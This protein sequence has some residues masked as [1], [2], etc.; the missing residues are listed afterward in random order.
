MKSTR[1]CSTVTPQ[2]LFVTSSNSFAKTTC[3]GL[4]RR[5]NS[6]F[7]VVASTFSPAIFSALAPKPRAA[8]GRHVARGAT[9]PRRGLKPSLTSSKSG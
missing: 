5:T 7:P 3:G 9:T 6:D 1:N 8:F 4:K 2:R